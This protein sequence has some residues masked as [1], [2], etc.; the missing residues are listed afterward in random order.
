MMLFLQ[1]D[2]PVCCHPSMIL[3]LLNDLQYSLTVVDLPLLNLARFL[4]SNSWQVES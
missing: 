2:Q 4:G 1:D 3:D